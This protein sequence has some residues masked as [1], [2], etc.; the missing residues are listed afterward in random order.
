MQILSSTDTIAK[1]TKTGTSISFPYIP[2]IHL[3]I[4]NFNI[5][6]CPRTFQICKFILFRFPFSQGMNSYVVQHLLSTHVP[7]QNIPMIGSRPALSQRFDTTSFPLSV[8]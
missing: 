2:T 5:I 3:I 6:Y 8:P 4:C 1:I 7:T